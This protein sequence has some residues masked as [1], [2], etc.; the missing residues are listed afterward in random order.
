MGHGWGKQ[1]RRTFPAIPRLHRW[2]GVGYGRG[3]GRLGNFIQQTVKEGQRA[4][5]QLICICAISK[6]PL[7]HSAQSRERHSSIR[8]NMT[9]IKD[10]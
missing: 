3:V 2:G 10:L 7:A 4:H 6:A 9:C 8:L 1:L 5:Y